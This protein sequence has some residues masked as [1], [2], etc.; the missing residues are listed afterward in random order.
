MIE[1]T[2][3]EINDCMEIFQMTYKNGRYEYTDAHRKNHNAD[4]EDKGKRKRGK[5]FYAPKINKT[6]IDYDENILNEPDEKE[7]SE[8]IEINKKIRNWW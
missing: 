8:Q 7:D 3:D 2:K 5:P 6:L 1:S 4:I